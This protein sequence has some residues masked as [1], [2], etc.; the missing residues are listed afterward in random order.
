MS[1]PF[2]KLIK[3]KKY[4]LI[5]KYFFIHEKIKIKFIIFIFYI[6]EFFPKR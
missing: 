3:Y 5:F 1:G 2:P 6:G 4:T